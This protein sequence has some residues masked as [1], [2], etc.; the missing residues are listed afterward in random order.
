MQLTG[1]SKVGKTE[2][3]R[4]IKRIEYRIREQKFI[5]EVFREIRGN[6]PFAN[7][8]ELGKLLKENRWIAEKVGY[9]E[10]MV[11]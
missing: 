10:V 7:L 3:E 2:I 1:M 11:R 4:L 8:Q 6:G 5:E 9:W